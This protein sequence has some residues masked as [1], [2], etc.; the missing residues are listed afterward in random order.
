MREIV[1]ASTNPVKI[2]A[3]KEAFDLMFPEEEH[4]YKGVSVPSEVSDQ[5]MSDEETLKGAINRAR[6]ARETVTNG[7]YW[8]GIEGGVTKSKHGLE[9]F[10]WIAIYDRDERIGVAKTST[11]ILPNKIA[12]LVHG[13]MELGLA[14][15]KVFGNENS[16]Q[17]NGTVGALTNNV[18][19]RT[20]YYV[21]AAILALIPF[22]NPELYPPI[23]ETK[24]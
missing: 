13:G 10:A 1:V 5:P 9:A 21:Q 24:D 8:I 17:K 15:D 12:E 19:D 14:D 11:F 18:V 2:N 3:T 16:K 4:N 22:K 20:K 23:A 7:D 6:N